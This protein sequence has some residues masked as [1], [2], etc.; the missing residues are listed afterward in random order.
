VGV[1]GVLVAFWVVSVSV[2]VVVLVVAVFI[3]AV[4]CFFC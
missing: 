1:F 3:I 4:C 2:S